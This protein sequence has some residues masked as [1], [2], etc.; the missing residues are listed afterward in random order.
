MSS[1]VSAIKIPATSKPAKSAIIFVHGLGDSGE[2][3]SWFPQ[4]VRQLG[5]IK[6]RDSINYVFPNAPSMPI[7]A[8]GGY[9]MPAWFDIFA[10][11][12]S[13]SPQDIPGFLKSCEVL[14]SLIKEQIEVNNVPPEKIILGGFSQGAAIS[15]AT[16]SS[17]DFKIGGVVALSGFCNI[18]ETVKKNH[19]KDG[20]NF[21][22]PVFQGHGTED[23]L[24]ALSFAQK[25]SEL[26]K[27]LGF[28]KY[29]FKTYAGMAHSSNEAELNDVM[30]F[31]SKVIDS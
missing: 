12:S 7:T 18:P 20:V 16:L 22:T 15:L 8:N 19:N 27:G 10:F 28:S 2:G 26:Y 13:D 17:L 14:K 5:I 25:A 9:V 3:W 6:S 4:L 21:E 31:I 1:L 30:N 11:G 29:T 23:P 24:V